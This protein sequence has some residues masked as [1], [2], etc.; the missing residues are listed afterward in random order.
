MVLGEGTQ[1]RS[2]IRLDVMGSQ[3]G[4]ALMCWG[5]MDSMLRGM[6][7]RGVGIRMAF[8]LSRVFH[9]ISFPFISLHPTSSHLIP[10]HPS[11]HYP[12]SAK[13]LSNT[14]SSLGPSPL[15][16]S[17]AGAN[18]AFS[19]SRYLPPHTYTTSPLLCSSANRYAAARAT[20]PG[21]CAS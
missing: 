17:Y 21:D 11:T 15:T 13:I 9:F 6:H 19:I 12:P 7:K 4:L 3:C 16:F 18:T 1:G 8:R 2:T 5:E 20:T 10:S 14:S